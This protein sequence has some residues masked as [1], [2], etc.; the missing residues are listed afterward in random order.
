[1]AHPALSIDE[2][3]RERLVPVEGA[4]PHIRGIEMF[5]NSILARPFCVW[6]LPLS[7]T[8]SPDTS[9]LSDSWCGDSA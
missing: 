1:M 7:G 8:G 5:G 4:I 3:L 9:D 6:P 2:Y